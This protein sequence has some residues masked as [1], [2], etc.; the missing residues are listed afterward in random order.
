[1]G[2]KQANDNEYDNYPIG[3]D[4]VGA[5]IDY[6]LLPCLKKVIMVKTNI[7]P[8]LP[9]QSRNNPELFL[10]FLKMHCHYTDN[11]DYTKSSLLGLEDIESGSK[12]DDSYINM[13]FGVID[14]NKLTQLP[15][16]EIDSLNKFHK[17]KI[18]W[19]IRLI[20]D[21]D[22]V[23]SKHIDELD[24]LKNL[25][26]LIDP[27][28]YK[29]YEEYV[30]GQL[31]PKQDFYGN[32]LETIYLTNVHSNIAISNDKLALEPIKFTEVSNKEK[33]NAF[34]VQSGGNITKM[35]KINLELKNIK[36]LYK[37]LK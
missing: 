13:L 27:E 32:D 18:V 9:E 16:H 24:S 33:N 31:P 20:L 3:E 25:F 22:T 36:K 30:K 7:V 14:T 19:Y 6:D 1:M 35:D 28:S 34:F 4:I 12:N 8:M 2:G 37:A 10:E 11:N 23:N 5:Q 15:Q 17:E 21:D 26:K 29:L